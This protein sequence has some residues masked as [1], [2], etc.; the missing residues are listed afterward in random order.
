MKIYRV[1]VT[2]E[3]TEFW[4]VRA[5]SKDDARERV[6][7]DGVIVSCTEDNHGYVGIKEIKTKKKGTKK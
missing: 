7:E 5:K 3:K 6:Y 1:E 2:I 4:E